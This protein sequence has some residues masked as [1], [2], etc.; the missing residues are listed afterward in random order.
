[1]MKMMLRKIIKDLIQKEIKLLNKKISVPP[2]SSNAAANNVNYKPK[3]YS[4]L[5]WVF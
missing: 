4:I 2:A 5:F 3:K 1:M